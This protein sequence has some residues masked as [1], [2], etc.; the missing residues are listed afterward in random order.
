MIEFDKRPYT[1][2]VV[3]LWYRA[4]ELLLGSSD[5]SPAVDM[6]SLGCI[7]YELVMKVPPFQSKSE[8][9]QIKMIFDNLGPPSKEDFGNL[10]VG[11]SFDKLPS[12]DQTFYNKMPSDFVASNGMDLLKKM[13]F[14]DQNKRITVKEA[15][16]HDYFS[17][18]D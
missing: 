17:Q 5:Y 18:T 8:S 9:E 10:N 7:F 1:N 12:I 2:N 15:L 13:F 6:W 4:P 14:Y 3:S 11:T 16:N